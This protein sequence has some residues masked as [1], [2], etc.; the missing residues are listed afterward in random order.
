M[1]W[2]QKIYSVEEVRAAAKTRQ[3][4]AFYKEAMNKELAKI[5]FWCNN[6]SELGHKSWD[7]CLRVYSENKFDH[8]H[9]RQRLKELGYKVSVIWWMTPISQYWIRIRW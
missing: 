6:A 5:T 4:A 8:K 2:D 3:V 1:A 7:C 9:I